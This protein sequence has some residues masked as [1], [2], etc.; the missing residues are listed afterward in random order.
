MESNDIL[1][2]STKTSGSG[3]GVSRPYEEQKTKWDNSKEK[4]KKSIMEY[5][6]RKQ[7]VEE[8]FQY[9]LYPVGVRDSDVDL[10]RYFLRVPLCMFQL[11]GFTFT[12]I[13]IYCR[14][15]DVAINTKINDGRDSFIAPNYYLGDPLG[16]SE[17]TV[18]R[19]LEKMLSPE[20]HMIEE[21]RHSKGFRLLTPLMDYF[22]NED[23]ENV[24][25]IRI[26]YGFLNHP[27]LKREIAFFYSYLYTYSSFFV[28]QK[29]HD[30]FFEF[31]FPETIEKLKFSRR[32]LIRYI[33]RLHELGLIEI[34]E[35][36]GKPFQIKTLF[37]LDAFYA[38]LE[39]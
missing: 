37:N 35:R 14:L 25:F 1:I 38:P 26:Y 22:H 28:I 7:Q 15:Y 17:L 18:K 30:G 33:K 16:L 32:S 21:E 39:E 12:D 3:I 4:F 23:N 8:E 29:A 19:S 34:Y 10:C 31:S 2:T 27:Q 9:W 11:S 13:L 6:P 24:Q 36:K 20:Y 5:Q